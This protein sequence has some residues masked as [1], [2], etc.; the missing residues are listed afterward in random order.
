MITT[1]EVIVDDTHFVYSLLTRR[2]Y[3]LLTTEPHRQSSNICIIISSCSITRT[4]QN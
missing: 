2:T 3:R 4:P 1:K